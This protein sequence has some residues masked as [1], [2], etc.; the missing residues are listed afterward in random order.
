MIIGINGRIGH[1]KDYVGKMIKYLTLQDLDKFPN[2]KFEEYIKDFTINE[3]DWEIRKFAK[4][5][6][7]VASILTGIPVDDFEKEEVKS[8][9]LGKEW[10]KVAIDIDEFGK[11]E[12]HNDVT[13][14][15]TVREFLQ[16]LGTDAI[17]NSVHQNAWVNAL[18]SKYDSSNWIITDVRFHNEADAIK[19]RGGIMIR[20]V[21]TGE[22][23]FPKNEH[24]SETALDDYKFDHLII[25]AK[26]DI[27]SMIKQTKEILIK[28]NIL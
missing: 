10:N 1:G 16:R 28:E 22:G 24:I 5:L 9:Y 7:E 20:V 12:R 21:K 2:Y 27:E 19:E 15:M 11:T 18:M 4:A 8:S 14:H 17:R 6:K 3:N 26:G 23:S 25:A 13:I